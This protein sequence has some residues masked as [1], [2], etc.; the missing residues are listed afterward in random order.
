MATYIEG[1]YIT[2]SPTTTYTYPSLNSQST[3]VGKPLILILAQD[4]HNT[5]V[6][7]P[8]QV[9]KIV[10]ASNVVIDTFELI[11]N[12]TGNQNCIYKY[13]GGLS[14]NGTD[15][16]IR[17]N[18]VSNSAYPM[19]WALWQMDNVDSYSVGFDR[20][21][22]TGIQGT[23]GAYIAWQ[24]YW[25]IN[26]GASSQFGELLGCWVAQSPASI[27]MTEFLTNYSGPTA[28]NFTKYISYNGFYFVSQAKY[29]DFT[30]VQSYYRT[31]GKIDN[32][33]IGTGLSVR[34][35]V[36]RTD[37]AQRTK[38]VLSAIGRSARY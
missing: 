19:F 3:S 14:L 28:T 31:N 7:D 10:N 35:P 37:D 25:Q 22:T 16:K 29:I 20:Q 13:N 36:N 24:S 23:G 11:A 15:S 2:G 30:P 6:T 33:G 32:A 4:I 12:N 9:P 26:D 1:G 21:F 17:I 38:P 18:G 34:L 8:T 5:T 27:S